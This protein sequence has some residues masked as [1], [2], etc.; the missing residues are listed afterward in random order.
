M[1]KCKF[2]NHN[3][4]NYNLTILPT[5]ISRGNDTIA[6]ILGIFYCLSEKY[7]YDNKIYNAKGLQVDQPDVTILKSNYKCDIKLS[8][9]TDKEKEAHIFPSLAEN[10]LI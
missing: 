3:S 2:R 10:P 9:L 6:D 5:I 1:L 4:I 8:A 7:P